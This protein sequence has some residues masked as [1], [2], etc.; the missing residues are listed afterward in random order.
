LG[1]KRFLRALV[2]DDLYGR[3]QT[4]APRVAYELEVCRLG[5]ALFEQFYF[6]RHGLDD[7]VFLEQGLGA[8]PAIVGCL[9]NLFAENYD[10]LGPVK[11]REKHAQTSLNWLFRQLLKKFQY[12][13]GRE[14]EVWNQWV[15][16]ITS[17]EVQEVLDASEELQKAIRTTLED[18][19]SPLL[20]SLSKVNDWLKAFQRV[21][22][23]EP[24]PEPEPEPELE[25]AAEPAQEAEA[26]E[27]I[28]PPSHAFDDEGVIAQGSYH[29]QLLLRKMQAFQHLV[30]KQEFNK[31]AIVAD[32]INDIIANFD[33]RIYFPKLFSRYS[34]LRALNIGQLNAFEEY[35]ESVEWQTMQ[36]LYKVD[37][38]SFVS[39][40]AVMSYSSTASERAYG[41]ED[42]E[43]EE[44]ESD[45]EAEGSPE[46]W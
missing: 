13:E 38:D 19:A 1:P 16:Q 25:E 41:E 9:T 44:E 35:K 33:P 34:L 45:E 8:M 43:Y 23:R 22:Y 40:D 10:A 2:G 5:K 42:Y 26:S 36:D 31:A 3:H 11:N 12:E 20:D 32:D 6:G 7:G 39:L 28:A 24:A 18:K 17:E 14:S 37:L 30:D 27:M 46:D 21:V 15:Q 4:A 29:L